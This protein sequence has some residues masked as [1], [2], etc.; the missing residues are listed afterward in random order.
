MP[1][2]PARR[3][4]GLGLALVVG[5]GCAEARPPERIVLVV[6]DTLRRDHVGAYGGP[7]RTPVLDALAARGQRFEALQAS[8]HQT[9][10]SMAALFTG[11]TP[12]LELASLEPSL[13]WNGSTWCG[14]A[15]FRDGA[16][17]DARCIPE[18]LPT[19]AEGLREA[20]YWTLGIS[21]NELLFE[22]SGFSRGFDDWVEVGTATLGALQLPRADAWRDRTARHVLEATRQALARRPHDRLFLYVHLMEVHDYGA[23]RARNR[24]EAYLGAVAAADAALGRLLALLAREGLRD[25]ALVVVSSDH[26]ERLDEAHA[27]EGRPGHLGNPSFQE[28]LEVPLLAAPALPSE[29]AGPL[30]TQDLYALL[31]AAAGID[32]RA[33]LELAPGELLLGERRYRTYSDG[34]FKTTVRRSDGA[35]H[36]FDLERD[37]GERTDVA[38]AHPEVV[39]RQLSRIQELSEAF[40]SEGTSVGELSPR[41]RDRLRALG[42]LE[43]E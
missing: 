12:S 37:P 29:P 28:V 42:Y 39:R 41:D 2:E 35:L 7:A 5:L 1:S 13:P 8:F 40:A 10:M 20:G 26:G 19:L 9:S 24:R 21:S 16:E 23:R 33:P 38:A 43:D 25:D 36:L 27:L 32:A 15:R 4:A 31:L 6:I 17:S 3:L 11:R 14:L 34:R 30:R 22:P 18:G